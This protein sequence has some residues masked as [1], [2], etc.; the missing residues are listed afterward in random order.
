R[1]P[2]HLGA[3]GNFQIFLQIDVDFSHLDE[4]LCTMKFWRVDPRRTGG[5]SAAFETVRSRLLRPGHI[6]CLSVASSLRTITKAFEWD[7]TDVPVQK[8]IRIY[9]CCPN[10]YPDLTFTI[11]IRRKTLFYT[12][13]LIVPCV[14]ISFLTTFVFYLPQRREDHSER[15]DFWLALTVFFLLLAEIIPPTSLVVPLIGKYLLFTMVLVTL[16]IVVTVIVLNVHFC[17]PLTNQMSPCRS[18]DCFW[19]CCRGFCAC[20]N[21]RRNVSKEQYRKTWPWWK[22]PTGRNFEAFHRRNA[23]CRRRNAATSAVICQQVGSAERRDFPAADRPGPSNS[24]N[25]SL[26][27]HTIFMKFELVHALEGTLGI[28][29]QAPNLFTSIQQCRSRPPQDIAT[30]AGLNDTVEDLQ[31]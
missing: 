31:S 16:S 18:G 21:R 28:I 13:N 20:R 26:Y 6:L 2:N 29:F 17:D 25:Y 4:Q 1:R 19:A 24:S 23:D 22:P 11:R 12:V 14:A 3:A 7:V 10:L 15:V 27:K 30:T 8:N 5:G 9:P